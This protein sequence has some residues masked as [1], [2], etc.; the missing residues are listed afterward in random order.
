VSV[1]QPLKRVAAGVIGF[2]LLLPSLVALVHWLSQHWQTYVVLLI[3]SALCYL[4]LR[5]VSRIRTSRTS[6]QGFL[7]RVPYEPGLDPL[8][9]P[10]DNWES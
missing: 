1:T 8:K 9:S 6:P 3:V 7:E 4:R 2:V 10:E 5:P